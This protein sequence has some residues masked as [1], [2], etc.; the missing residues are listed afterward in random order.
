MAGVRT[1]DCILPL[2]SSCQLA[3]SALEVLQ[4]DWYHLQAWRLQDVY[5]DTRYQERFSLFVLG[6]TDNG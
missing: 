5:L 4:C 2:L 6:G 3:V 1:W